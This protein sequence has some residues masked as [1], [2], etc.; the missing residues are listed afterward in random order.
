MQCQITYSLPLESFGDG[1]IRTDDIET[2]EAK[3]FEIC[4][5]DGE[6]GLTWSEVEN[7][8]VSLH[9]TLSDFQ[10]NFFY[11]IGSDF[12]IIIYYI[13]TEYRGLSTM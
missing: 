8:L 5:T 1:S 2:V 4:N 13:L 9:F 3:A 12:G 11:K 6:K 10:K 7:C